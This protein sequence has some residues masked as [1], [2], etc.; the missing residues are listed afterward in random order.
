[1]IVNLNSSDVTAVLMPKRLINFTTE[2]FSGNSAWSHHSRS[3][4]TSLPLKRALSVVCTMLFTTLQTGR[5]NSRQLPQKVTF[6]GAFIFLQVGDENKR[7][8][9]HNRLKYANTTSYKVPRLSKNL[10]DKKYS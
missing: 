5:G 4:T 10:S 9:L 7:G 6:N 1:M 8:T 2:L 3:G